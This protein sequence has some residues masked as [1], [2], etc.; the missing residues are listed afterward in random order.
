M[1][2]VHENAS[3]CRLQQQLRVHRVP[4]LCVRFLLLGSLRRNLR[5]SETSMLSHVQFKALIIG[6]A[7]LAWAIA[8]GTSNDAAVNSRSGQ[9]DCPVGSEGCPCTKGG[10]CDKGLVCFD[11]LCFKPDAAGPAGTGGQPQGGINGVAGAGSGISGI[12]TGGRSN[13]GGPSNSGGSTSSGGS[14]SSGGSSGSAGS[15][16]VGGSVA[17]A[18]CP[19][20][21]DSV[22]AHKQSDLLGGTKDPVAAKF[23]GGRLV[24]LDSK[25][26][27]PDSSVTPTGDW[28]SYSCRDGYSCGGCVV[29]VVSPG[30][31]NTLGN[32]FLLGA[33][34]ATDGAVQG[35]PAL[36]G[37]YQI[38][39]PD[40]AGKQCG[41]DGCGSFCGN[42][43]GT[44]NCCNPQNQCVADTCSQCLDACN[45]ACGS[46]P[47]CASS[48]CTGNGCQCQ[49]ACPGPC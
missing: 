46:I 36:S 8:C 17:P 41:D 23:S 24:E 4:D 1:R 33:Y 40:C 47:S 37:G 15:G 29:F 5:L 20:P 13:D 11:P 48:C 3:D 32:W 22:T 19:F 34:T 27:T 26:C 10:G 6:P 16:G 28:G 38:C 44:G 12:V 45:D 35:C 39:V 14:P 21:V 2:R 7:A 43:C 42:G 9:N 30:D 25:A 31:Q 49:G 18:T